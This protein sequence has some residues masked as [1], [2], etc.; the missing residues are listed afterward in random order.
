MLGGQ[1]RAA[2]DMQGSSYA[3][4]ETS[5]ASHGS[6]YLMTSHGSAYH[7]PQQIPNGM[8][9][10]VSVHKCLH[11]CLSPCPHTHPHTCVCRHSQRSKLMACWAAQSKLVSNRSRWYGQR[12]SIPRT[13]TAL[14][15]LTETGLMAGCC[16]KRAVQYASECCARSRLGSSGALGVD[17][18]WRIEL[19]RQHAAD[20][21]D[22]LCLAISR[23]QWLLHRAVIPLPFFFFCFAGMM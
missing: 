11:T 19:G 13:A 8:H 1:L 18:F 5:L 21:L 22:R 2:A 12:K 15:V 16:N 6:A 4:P 17:D 20:D 7:A 3:A 10:K 9:H 14:V 23:S